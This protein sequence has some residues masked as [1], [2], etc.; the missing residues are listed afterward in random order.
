MN[1]LIARPRKA[2]LPILAFLFSLVVVAL[3]LL[4]ITAQ[5]SQAAARGMLLRP[6]IESPSADV[7][8]IGVA[9]DLSDVASGIG[10]RQANSVVLLATQ[11][12]ASGGLEIGGKTYDLQVAI[13]D[14]KCLDD[15]V[16]ENAANWL[17]SQGAVGV[18]GHTCSKSSLAAQDIYDAEGIPMIS[19]SS[20]NP[21]ITENGYD[22]TFRV[23]TRDDQPSSRLGIYFY[24]HL[25]FRKVAVV[26]MDY[27]A[28]G[29]TDA[30]ITT[31][32]DLGGVI[33]NR[34]TLTNISEYADT[35]SAIASEGVDAI[36]YNGRFSDE[37]GQFSEAVDNGGLTTIPVAWISGEFELDLL[38]EYLTEA[39]AAAENDLAMLQLWDKDE[40]PL[41]TEF[42][43]AYVAEAFPVDGDAGL[44]WGAYAYDAAQILINAIQAADSAN[45]ADILAALQ[46]AGSHSGVVGEYFGFD[47]KGDVLPQWM[48]FGSVRDGTWKELKAV[49][50]VTDIG[51]INDNGFNQSTYQGIQRAVT[52]DKIIATFFESGSE[53]DYLPFL[54]QCAEDGNQLCI[55]SS[56]L[57]SERIKEAANNY[58]A[59]KFAI[60]DADISEAPANLRFYL[61]ANDEAGYMAGTLAGLMTKSNIVGAVG[62]IEGVTAVKDLVENYGHAA[63]CA[64][65]SATAILTFTETFTD[66]DLG[67]ETAEDQMTLG[68]DI[69]FGA[70]GP[71]G[72][73]AILYAAQNGAYVIGVDTDQYLTLFEGG[74]VYGSEFILSS[75]MKRL[76]NSA[77]DAIID[78]INGSFTSG[79]IDFGLAESGIGLAPFHETDAIIPQYVKNWLDFI[80]NKIIAGELDLYG[81]C[82]TP[83][84]IYLPVIVK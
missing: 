50:L 31:F 63:V 23:V 19:A 27:G 8:T 51:G 24:K 29:L 13:F 44:E 55:A 66:P 68:A 84:F 15:T 47:A 43:T 83:K 33:S 78:L 64:N 1:D 61:F 69:I 4:S 38:D 2:F 71:T 73:G 14:S 36:L 82:L 28:L 52:E 25:G 41:Y 53:S 37:A 46:N 16:S 57:L 74:T 65:P 67:E 35:V 34:Y 17:V 12:N 22:T 3:L 48:W 79:G 6:G 26:E 62:G 54:N 75:A 10:N 30:F 77:Y 70:A 49:T 21:Q 18:I 39:G 60:Q 40:M 76:D 7:I 56:F 5:A 58:P 59:V 9:A 42:N 20:T 81:A 72:N 11:I 32:T 80:E 45:P